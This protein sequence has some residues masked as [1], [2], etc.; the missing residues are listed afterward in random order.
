MNAVPCLLIAIGISSLLGCGRSG[1]VTGTVTYQGS[2]VVSGTVT[3]LDSNGVVHQVVI[4]PDGTYQIEGV[5]SGTAKIG[6]T[7]PD[8]VA[9]SKKVAAW[10]G[11]RSGKGKQGSQTP[12]KHAATATSTGWFPLPERFA[13]PEQSGI[14]LD[15]RGGRNTMPIALTD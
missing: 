5:P 15:I 12:A 2:P 3:L 6:V 10:Q 9:E 7:S 13:D 1:K 8:P 11:S 14:A 4:G